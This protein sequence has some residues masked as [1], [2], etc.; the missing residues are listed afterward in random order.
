MGIFD[1]KT[2]MVV[3]LKDTVILESH[4]FKTLPPD[5]TG[6][7]HNAIAGGAEM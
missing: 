6:G 2:L 3:K 5:E 1:R 7:G 4:V